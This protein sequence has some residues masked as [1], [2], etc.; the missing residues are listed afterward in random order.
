MKYPIDVEK[1]IAAMQIEFGPNDAVEQMHQVAIPLV[2]EA[3][4]DG[5]SGAK[6]R[7]QTPLE[8]VKRF[9][10]CEGEDEKSRE[11]IELIAAWCNRAYE[12]GREDALTE[13]KADA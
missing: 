13:Q 1:Y 7:F 11:V 6:S 10:D 9:E 8:E 3:Y 2:N 5:L 4:A 12:Q